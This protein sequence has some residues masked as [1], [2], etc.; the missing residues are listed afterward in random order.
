MSRRTLAELIG[1]SE[2]WLRL[3]ETGA[4]PLDS[5]Q[6]VVRL[7][8]VLRLRDPAELLDGFPP[9]QRTPIQLGTEDPWDELRTAA[10][11][12]PQAGSV[13]TIGVDDLWHQWRFCSRRSTTLRQE[14]PIRLAEL[15]SAWQDRTGDEA[16]AASLIDAYHLARSMV[17]G[18]EPGLALLVADRAVALAERDAPLRRAAAAR[19]LAMALL[20][21]GDYA[22]ALRLAQTV[23]ASIGDRPPADRPELLLWGSLQSIAAKAAARRNDIENTRRLLAAAAD[24]AARA[25]FDDAHHNVWFGPSDLHLTRMSTAINLGQLQ[26]IPVLAAEAEF[27]DG[28]PPTLQAA[29]YV[30]LAYV[31]ARRHDAAAAAM[32][33]DRVEQLC[34]DE[35]T[36][37][38]TVTRTL[39]LLLQH[40]PV[41]AEIRRLA[42]LAGIL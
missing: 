24:A 12:P 37:N 23:A 14:L 17:G 15:R 33:L 32:A 42:R 19:N 13:A 36:D 28:Y 1:R 22:R 29:Y 34:A 31:Y 39:H 7:A 10:V 21:T 16:L 2:E 11:E 20:Q 9:R 27:S 6:A 25:A 41:P 35:I 26:E 3:I 40:Q 4:R 8:E 30:M 38:A 18:S 5:V